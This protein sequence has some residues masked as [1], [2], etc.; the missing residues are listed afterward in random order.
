MRALALIAWLAAAWFG[1]AGDAVAQIYAG[2]G[3]ATGSVVLS[4]FESNDAPELVVAMPEAPP[5]SQPARPPPRKPGAA[6][7]PPPEL[8]RV[9]DEVARQVAI[10]PELLHAVITVESAYDVRALSPRGAMGLMQLLPATARRFGVR[11][12]YAPRDNI[13]GGAS[14][15][16]WLMGVFDNDLTLVLAAYNAGEQA[17][18]KAGRQVPPFAETQAYVPRVM[19]YL[20]CT[21]PKSC[22]IT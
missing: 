9:I 18:I 7:Q 2:R 3:G 11:D 15:L 5:A 22:K 8:R 1:V 20:R 16:K 21:P 13:M 6:A 10:S 12:P 14:Y 4:N 17:V 19:S